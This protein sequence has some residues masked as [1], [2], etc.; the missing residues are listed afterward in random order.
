MCIRE[1][2]QSEKLWNTDARWKNRESTNLNGACVL[3]S[4]CF[5]FVS[6]QCV[7]SDSLE[8][9]ADVTS[10]G[11]PAYIAAASDVSDIM[12]LAHAQNQH[13][14]QMLSHQTANNS[15]GGNLM[16]LSMG[17]M[18]QQPQQSAHQQNINS[19]S[20]D[21]KPDYGLTAL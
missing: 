11:N 10:L 14:Q 1:F 18:H 7:R 4:V 2:I 17:T 16:G 5:F 12:G 8:S 13:Q 20:L 19:N 9:M 21:I 6:L 15:N 3:V